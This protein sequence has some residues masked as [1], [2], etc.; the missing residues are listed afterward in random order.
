[1][2]LFQKPFFLVF[3]VFDKIFLK[4]VFLFHQN[5]KENNSSKKKLL[6]DNFVEETK[7]VLCKIRKNCF[8]IQQKKCCFSKN[9]S[10]LKQGIP[11]IYD[12]VEIKKIGE[13][14]TSIVLNIVNKKETFIIKIFLEQKTDLIFSKKNNCLIPREIYILESLNHPGIIKME[15]YFK[16]KDK[17]F[18]FL[19][20]G[21]EIL[22][23]LIFKN[24]KKI[25]LSIFKTIQIISDILEIICY[26]IKEKKIMH[27]DIKAK[28]IVLIKTDNDIKTKLIDF[29]FSNF[30][31]EQGNTVSL[32]QT[33]R[34]FHAPECKNMFCSFNAEKAEIFSLGY[35]Y[36]IL[37]TSK[38]LKEGVY[39]TTNEL[40]Y[41]DETCLIN[42]MLNE[43]PEK[44]PNFEEVKQSLL[45]IK[46]NHL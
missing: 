30:I 35:L 42:K 6:E 40:L 29:G 34:L 10:Y 22:E 4:H 46:N 9:F 15:A 45:N 26:L 3:F 43:N 19:E 21:H 12:S 17:Y 25:L 7:Q 1:M 18:L 16:E 37:R 38:R 13:G 39:F 41:E 24:N 14:S 44:R 23:N 32:K 36:H 31:D 2:L 27:G 8:C 5:Q 20:K 28:N 11:F 33:N